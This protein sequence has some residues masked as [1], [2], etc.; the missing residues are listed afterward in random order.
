VIEPIQGRVV[1]DHLLTFCFPKAALVRQKRERD[2]QIIVLPAP[3]VR[4]TFDFQMAVPC[5]GAFAEYAQRQI[6]SQESLR[7]TAVGVEYAASLGLGGQFNEAF[8]RFDRGLAL[9]VRRFLQGRAE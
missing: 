9:R 2:D 5:S 6:L 7:K 3:A 1:M 4:S 8:E